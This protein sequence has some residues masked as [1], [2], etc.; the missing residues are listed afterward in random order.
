MTRFTVLISVESVLQGL[1]PGWKINKISWWVTALECEKQ[2]HTLCHAFSE[3]LFS[4][5]CPVT[6]G[7]PT[8]CCFVAGNLFLVW[9]TTF[10][11]LKHFWMIVR[12]TSLL[13]ICSHMTILFIE[14]AKSNSS[15]CYFKLHGHTGSSLDRFA[16]A[17]FHK[18]MMDLHAF[19]WHYLKSVIE[20]NS[21]AIEQWKT[22]SMTF[23]TGEK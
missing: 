7:L 11:A 6:R 20:Q 22:S 17:S 21:G 8:K 14:L 12:V 16:Q 13:Q 9:T 18:I 4:L 15:K 1:I 19:H 23:V 2:S 10:L 3:Y 5:L